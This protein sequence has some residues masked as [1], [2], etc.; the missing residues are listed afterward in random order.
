QRGKRRPGTLAQHALSPRIDRIDAPGV[1]LPAQK[2]QRPPGGLAR[3]IGLPNDGDRARREQC[4]AQALH[5]AQ[6]ARRGAMRLSWLSMRS[7][8]TSRS[9][10]DCRPIQNDAVVPK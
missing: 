5:F 1:A 3:I 7:D 2:L 10:W 9:Y 4:V 8:A 6:A